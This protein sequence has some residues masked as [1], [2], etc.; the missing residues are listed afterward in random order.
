MSLPDSSSER[1]RYTMSQLMALQSSPLVSK[2]INL[3][4]MSSWFTG[5]SSP[6][7]QRQHSTADAHSSRSKPQS[8]PS[9]AARRPS[10]HKKDFADTDEN[11]IPEWMDDTPSTMTWEQHAE[12]MVQDSSELERW[13]QQMKAQDD[14]VDE[15]ALARDFK[16]MCVN[17]SRDEYVPS[18]EIEDDEGH[19]DDSDL[20]HDHPTAPDGPPMKCIS[21]SDLFQS[22]QH[23]PPSPVEHPHAMSETEV[24]QSLASSAVSDDTVH[25]NRNP[26]P[27]PAP[28][29]QQTHQP[30]QPQQQHHQQPPMPGN[31]QMMFPPPGFMLPSPE[32]RAPPSF[33]SMKPPPDMMY[34][35]IPGPPPSFGMHPP[36]PGWIPPSQLAHPMARMMPPYPVFPP[37]HTSSHPLPYPPPPPPGAYLMPMVSVNQAHLGAHQASPRQI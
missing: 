10:I 24:M 34:G 37:P 32:Y 2:P 20:A 16:A 36:P 3:P 33:S 26:M 18:N 11:A 6:R 12:K 8:Y 17:V 14:P 29:H 22:K 15:A 31:P 13:I 9:P 4:P 7:R 1:R 35:M 28:Q 19:G 30:Q 27:I 25:S 5:S 23:L 21:V